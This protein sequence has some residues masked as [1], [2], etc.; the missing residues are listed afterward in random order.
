MVDESAVGG[1]NH[2]VSYLVNN[3]VGVIFLEVGPR[4]EVTQNG[5]KHSFKCGCLFHIH[6]LQMDVY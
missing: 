2:E 4:E 6:F 1:K 3:A 5:I